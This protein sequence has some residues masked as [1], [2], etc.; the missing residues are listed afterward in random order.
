MRLFQSHNGAIAAMEHVRRLI[1][2][3]DAFQSHN[4]AIAAV[5]EVLLAPFEF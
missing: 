4:G 2:E 3:A 1:A 5:I